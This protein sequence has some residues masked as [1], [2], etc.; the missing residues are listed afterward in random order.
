MER[1]VNSA[2]LAVE[3]Q[4][5]S[6]IQGSV[7]LLSGNLLAN[8]TDP[9]LASDP[10]ERLIVSDVFRGPF[11]P[12]PV[13]DQGTIFVGMFG[14]FFVKADGSWTYV[15]DNSSLN[16]LSLRQGDT[17]LD[18]VEYRV[19]DAHGPSDYGVL[20]VS[21]SGSYEV[22]IGTDRDDVLVG[23][24][25]DDL[26]NG[27]KGADRLGGPGGANTVTYADAASGVSASLLTKRGSYGEAA[28]DR[29]YYIGNLI[30]SAHADV[31]AGDHYANAINGGAGDDII[32]GNGGADTL[33]GGAGND[34]FWVKGNVVADFDGGE[35]FDTIR[36]TGDNVTI[37]WTFDIA[38]DRDISIAGIEAIDGNG[39]ANVI[40]VGTA[41]EDD[42]IDLSGLTLT[43]IDRIDG[44]TGD[45]EIIGSTSSD[46]ILGG[47]GDDLLKGGAGDDVLIGGVGL[48][49]LE[50]GEGADTFVFNRGD[51]GR[52]AQ[53][54][55]EIWD[56]GAGDRIDLSAIDANSA[57]GAATNDSFAFIGT[58][59]FGK[60]AGQLRYEVAGTDTYVSADIN[61]DGKADFMLNLWGVSSLKAEDFVL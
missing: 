29:F 20:T 55:D 59:Q 19:T 50:G 25:Y 40:I 35:G 52:L 3:D 27:G 51:S 39:H 17:Q 12:N 7:A 42:T 37:N 26:F 5:G 18:G 1:T 54:A 22:F 16:T 10:D 33:E 58:A 46:R 11:E 4:G 36:A 34:L 45:D 15:L 57:N 47:G 21:I 32:E 53:L 41:G 13:T 49:R 30:G 31:L 8:D 14:K 28:G 56:F 6:L 43:G 23:T 9:D 44:R 48:D 38:N 24:A 61:G 60:V 2:P